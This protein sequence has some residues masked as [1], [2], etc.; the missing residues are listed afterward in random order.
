MTPQ[1][2]IIIALLALVLLV[3]ML[4]MLRKRR[5]NEEVSLIWIFAFIA[6][7]LLVGVPGLADRLTHLI[8]AVY[9]AS[10]LTLLAL[11]FIGV[12][13]VYTSVKI[14]KLTTEVRALAQRQVLFEVERDA[15][16]KAAVKTTESA[17]KPAESTPENVPEKDTA[18]SRGES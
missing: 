15:R 16:E 9:P 18:E 10:V 3:F 4:N 2:S 7:I 11:G 1:G 6:V 5:I 13:L 14:S 17:A 8:G 12:M